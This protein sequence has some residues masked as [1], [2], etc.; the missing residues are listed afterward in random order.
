M[1]EGLFV[2]AGENCENYFVTQCEGFVT[3]MGDFVSFLLQ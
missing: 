1:Y 3:I 2:K